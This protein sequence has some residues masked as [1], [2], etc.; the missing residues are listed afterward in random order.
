M[1]KWEYKEVKFEAQLFI[2]EMN[3]LGQEGWEIIMTH[4]FVDP[5]IMRATVSAYLKRQL[6]GRKKLL[7]S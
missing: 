5:L 7:Q 2:S 3:K 4:S 6:D 1:T